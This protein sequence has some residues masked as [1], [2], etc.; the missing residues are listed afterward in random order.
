LARYLRKLPPHHLDRYFTAQYFRRE[1][2]YQYDGHFNAAG[3]A[4][5]SSIIEAALATK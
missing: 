2:Y 4:N 5:M 3:H 1:S